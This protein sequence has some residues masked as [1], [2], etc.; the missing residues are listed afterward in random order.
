MSAQLP[1]PEPPQKEAERVLAEESQAP[2]AEATEREGA[3]CSQWEE[4]VLSGYPQFLVRK[5]KILHSNLS[6]ASNWHVGFD[7]VLKRNIGIKFLMT[8]RAQNRHGPVTEFM[9]ILYDY[10]CSYI[11]T[12][13]PYI[14]HQVPTWRYVYLN[15]RRCHGNPWAT[16]LTQL[17]SFGLEA[18][19]PCFVAFEADHFFIKLRVSEN[20][21]DTW[22][23]SLW[24]TLAT[25]KHKIT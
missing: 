11:P 21:W 17:L 4:T 14:S 9:H 1:P 15:Q 2:P 12:I 23:R 13:F 18:L 16:H 22:H 5:G 10:I 3:W 24:H 20:S 19:W 7:E 25:A 6:P 8:W